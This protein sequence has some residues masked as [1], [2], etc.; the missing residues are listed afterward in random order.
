[1]IE[2]V[3]VPPVEFVTVSAVAPVL[4]PHQV[5]PDPKTVENAP[6]SGSVIVPPPE[7]LTGVVLPMSPA[8]TEKDAVWAVSTGAVV[9]SVELLRTR[10]AP[11]AASWS[12]VP[13]SNRKRLAE[14]PEI[15]VELMVRP[16]PPPPLEL[17]V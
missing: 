7:M 5:C 4:I 11:R 14:P 3:I 6:L 15:V 9:F 12:F 16:E 13:S 10:P 2:G 1:M 17:T 8:A